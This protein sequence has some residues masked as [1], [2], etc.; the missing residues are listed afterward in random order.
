MSVGRYCA[1]GNFSNDGYV[2]KYS[3]D[4]RNCFHNAGAHIRERIERDCR[5]S[6]A[7]CIRCD[8][9]IDSRR[10]CVSDCCKPIDTAQNGRAGSPSEATN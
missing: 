6:E 5:A 3:S 1:D 8:R 2:R 10:H 7:G 9:K 4:F